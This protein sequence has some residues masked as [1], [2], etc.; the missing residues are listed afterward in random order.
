MLIPIHK[1]TNSDQ[2]QISLMLYE[3]RYCLITNLHCLINENSQMKHVCRRC[4]TAFSSQS[5]L[6]DQIDRGER[7]KPTNIAFSYENHLKFEDQHMK[8]PVPIRFY[9]DFEC[10]IQPQNDPNIPNVLFKQK[11]IAVK[12]FLISPNGKQYYSNSGLDCVSWIGNV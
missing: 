6:I 1:N 8:V 3:N 9:A 10:F 11:L 12:I 5:G 2:P 7:W 4:L